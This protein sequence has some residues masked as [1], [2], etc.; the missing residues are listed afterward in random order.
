MKED[1]QRNFSGWRNLLL[2]CEPPDSDAQVLCDSAFA[3]VN[4]LARKG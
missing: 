2:Y 4:Y 1:S 3:Q